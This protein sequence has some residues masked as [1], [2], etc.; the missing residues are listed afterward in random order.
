[1][2]VVCLSVFSGKEDN[3]GILMFG[4]IVNVVGDFEVVD[5]GYYNVEYYNLRGLLLYKV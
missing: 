3:V 4:C 5:I 1:M 2:E